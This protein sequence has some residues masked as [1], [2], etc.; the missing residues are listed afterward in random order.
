MG[1]ATLAAFFNGSAGGAGAGVNDFTSPGSGSVTI[2]SG[3]T[4]V[5]IEVWGAGGGGGYW[6]LGELAP[7]EPEIFPGG[8]GGGGGYARSVFVLGVGDALKTINY[9]VGAG[10]AGGTSGTGV[11]S[12]GTFSNVYSGSYTLT[13]MTANGGAGG[14]F[15]QFAGQGA[16]GTASGGNTVAGT[17]G[18]G[19]AAFTQAGAIP[20]TGLNSLTGGGG[21]DGGDA[22][23]G[24]PGQNGRVRMVF[25]F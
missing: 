12:A 3:A 20:L 17:T 24:Q 16:G 10:G 11:G 9:T 22:L 18:N 1:G 23:N 25:T 5:T 14:Q 13:T 8:G 6:F 19:G 2:P 4:G 21:G 15:G 7:G